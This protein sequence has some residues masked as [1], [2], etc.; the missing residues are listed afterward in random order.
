MKY[1]ALTTVSRD[2]EGLVTKISDNLRQSGATLCMGHGRQL[3][4]MFV[5]DTLFQV[6]DADF[7]RLAVGVKEGLKEFSPLVVDAPPPVA[8]RNPD[9]QHFTLTYNEEDVIGIVST[10]GEAI[11]T[12]GASIV[13][14]ESETLIAPTTGV[15]LFRVQMQ[16][17]I[18]NSLAVR[19]LRMEF[20]DFQRYKGWEIDFEP[21]SRAGLRVQATAPYPPTVGKRWAP[22]P[23]GPPDTPYAT[24]LKWAVLSTISADRAGIIASG[25]RFLA[26]CK[27]NIHSQTANR[28]G[29][30]F[31]AHY[32]FRAADADMQRIQRDYKELL[33]DFGPRL[34]EAVKPAPTADALRLELTVHAI[35]EPGILAAV[36]QPIASHGASIAQVAFGV[37]PGSTANANSTPLFVVEMSLLVRDFIAS[38]HIEAE[39]L[40]MERDRGWEVDYRPMR[41]AVDSDGANVEA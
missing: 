3:G 20:A 7:S 24:P 41:K 33:G 21:D 32:L 29:E 28:V 13:S 15:R 10:L 4:R 8:Y 18:P 22:E 23:T 36:S 6:D 14:L 25:S 35:D 5:F 17:D 34:V 16:L 1:G 31:A 26:Q 40:A 30:L 27:A 11:S 37:Y 39:L 2:R 12:H 38:R 9:A 19:N